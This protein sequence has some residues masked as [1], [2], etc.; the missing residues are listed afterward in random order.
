MASYSAPSEKYNGIYNPNYFIGREDET[1]INGVTDAVQVTGDYVKLDGSSIMQGRLTTPEIMLFNGG[2]VRFD[3]NTE[4]STAFTSSHIS[5][6]ATSKQKLTN[7]TSSNDDTIISGSL[8]VRSIVFLDDGSAEQTDAFQQS[9]IDDIANSKQKLTNSTFDAQTGV[10]TI[11]NLHATALTSGTFN[12]SHLSGTLSNV[13]TQL[14]TLSGDVTPLK[15]NC[16]QIRYDSQ[17]LTTT[18]PDNTELENVF[19]DKITFGYH[20]QTDAFTSLEKTKLSWLNID[21]NG[22]LINE[23]EYLDG[24]VQSTAYTSE[25]D[26]MLRAVN[27]KTT[28][29]T[30]SQTGQPS[31][32]ITG[33]TATNFLTLYDGYSDLGKITFPDLTQ[34][35][36]AYSTTE[37]SKT[38][39]QSATILPG[40]TK[41]TLFNGT[42][43][44]NT[45]QAD[46]LTFS[47]STQQTSAFTSSLKTNVVNL[48][49]N[50]RN[51]IYFPEGDITQIGGRIVTN[52]ISLY[53]GNILYSDGTLQDSAF[54]SVLKT[55]LTNLT[56]NCRNVIYY[57][58]EFNVDTT[59]IGGRIVTNNLR[60]YNGSVVFSDGST[61]ETAFTNDLKIKVDAMHVVGVIQVYAG[62]ASDPTGWFI[63]DGRMLSQAEYPALFAVIGQMYVGTKAINQALFFCIPDMRNLYV[64]GNAPSIN[65]TY[66]LPNTQST[67]ST[68]QFKPMQVQ[69]HKHAYSD[70]GE[71]ST[72]VTKI[73]S[74]GGS[75]TGVAN[76]SQ[77]NFYTSSETYN[78]SFVQE[79]NQETMP[80][81]ICMNY[82]IKY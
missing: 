27:G 74:S 24:S 30:A 51:V 60:L 81:S 1:L 36:T 68:A 78:E 79:S 29:I 46:T 35:T 58:N 76:D 4:Q 44:A 80:N 66:A 49:S 40:N 14:T 31:T 73:A 28:H 32:V 11:S 2:T 70:R 50:C 26:T 77:Q 61:Q 37:Q 22:M 57:D 62:V 48:T 33:S 10:L 43:S 55:N 54:T 25:L 45:F 42:I 75:I 65:N 39:H 52:Y 13:Q 3:D 23:I 64:R 15:T 21:A 8:Q 18:I 69:A 17:T 9:H 7:V 20:E 67:S 16:Q 47:D 56:S 59:Q 72:N 82:I 5:D 38:Q 41:L 19:C 53:N 6:I 12:S 71:G 34:Q 63:C